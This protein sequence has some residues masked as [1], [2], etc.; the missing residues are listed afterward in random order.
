MTSSDPANRRR[1]KRVVLQVPVVLLAETSERKQAQEQTQTLVVNAHGGLMKLKM[2][3]LAGQPFILMN[4]KSGMK[5]GCRVV[6]IEQPSPD[7]FAVAF[8]FDRPSP[9]FWPI[10]FPPADWGL[11]PS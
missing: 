7:Y 10:V 1:S 6:R 3:L 2:E 4:A 8:E 9:K 5:Q 11:P